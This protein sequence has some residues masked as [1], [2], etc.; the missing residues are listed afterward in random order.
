MG[1]AFAVDLF[2]I[3]KPP[4]AMTSAA[5]AMIKGFLLM[6]IIVS[7]TSRKNPAA[8]A[9]WGGSLVNAVAGAFRHCYVVHAGVLQVLRPLICLQI[10]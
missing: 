5:I 4:A 3:Q 8:P 1:A 9:T 6:L 2:H 7:N 10:P